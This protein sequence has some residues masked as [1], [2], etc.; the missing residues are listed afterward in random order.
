MNNL[1]KNII[2]GGLIF[3]IAGVESGHLLAQEPFHVGLDPHV[4]HFHSAMLTSSY[5]VTMSVATT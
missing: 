1:S 2:C 4:P 5:S 3:T